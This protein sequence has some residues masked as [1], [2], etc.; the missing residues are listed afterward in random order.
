M[1]FWAFE[2]HAHMGP[3][4]S[5]AFRCVLNHSNLKFDFNVANTA[6]KA[7]TTALKDTSM[8][9]D[10]ATVPTAA[11]MAASELV[12]QARRLAALENQLLR[13]YSRRFA[14]YRVVKAGKGD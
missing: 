13:K 2:R 14:T 6:A 11:P 3:C 7:V 10:L 9:G 5:V 8:G 12:G 1:C 4:L